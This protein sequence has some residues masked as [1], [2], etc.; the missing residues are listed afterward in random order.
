[1]ADIIKN[2]YNES[3]SYR[4]VIFQQGRDVCDFE[5]NEAQDN[6]IGMMSRYFKEVYSTGCY[7]GGWRVVASGAVNKVTISEGILFKSGKFV[8]NVGNT[9]LTMPAPPATGTRLDRIY[10]KLS[11]VEVTSVQDPSIIEGSHILGETALRAQ[12]KAEVLIAQ[13]G[14]TPTDGGGYEY[15]ELAVVTR[16]V[17]I[18]AINLADVVDSRPLVSKVSIKVSQVAPTAYNAGDFWYKEV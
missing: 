1:M 3:K 7:S 11:E 13:G 17:G 2:S 10:I 12:L 5:L 6:I 9:E 18:T 8:V 15:V 14:G 4:K 16:T